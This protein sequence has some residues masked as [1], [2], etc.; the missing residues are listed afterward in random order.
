VTEHSK[1]NGGP[2]DGDSVSG[3]RDRKLVKQNA[4]RCIGKGRDGSVSA[5][6]MP[7]VNM[8][9]APVEMGRRHR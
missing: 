5:G 9:D 4:L 6:V 8:D 3:G 7:A 2:D 1:A